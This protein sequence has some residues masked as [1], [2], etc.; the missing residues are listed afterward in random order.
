MPRG[1]DEI[2]LEF[3]V[4]GAVTKVTAIDPKTGI[5]ASIFGP[6]SASRADLSMAAKRKLEYVLKKQN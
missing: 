6:A 4:Q 3:V 5:E 2:Y 1:G